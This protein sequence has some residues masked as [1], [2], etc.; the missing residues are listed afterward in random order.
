M[1][2]LVFH[3]A[4]YYLRHAQIEFAANLSVN[5]EHFRHLVLSSGGASGGAIG[6]IGNIGNIGIGVEVRPMSDKRD[7][8]GRNHLLR[9]LREGKAVGGFACKK[10]FEYELIIR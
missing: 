9:D 6:T 1:L 8:E 2:V 4:F 10:Q 7:I 5:P 3:D